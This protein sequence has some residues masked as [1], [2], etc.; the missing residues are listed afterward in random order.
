EWQAEMSSYHLQEGVCTVCAQVFAA[1]LLV[2]VI[3]SKEMLLTLNNDWLPVETWPHT[4]NVAKYEGV[5]LCC[6]GMH[7]VDNIGALHMCPCC[8][9]L[10]SRWYPRQPK[11]TIVNFEYYGLS[12]LPVEVR[13]MLAGVTVITHHYQMKGAHSGCFPEKVSQQFNRG[14]VAILLQ[15][16]SAL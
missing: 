3:L 5:I 14:N 15:D 16:P 6:H 10:L 4:Y 1:E 12:E 8:C 9:R 13:S 2:D 7:C 11:D